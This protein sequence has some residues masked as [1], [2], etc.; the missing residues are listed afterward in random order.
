V[1]PRIAREEVAEL[2]EVEQSPALGDVEGCFELAV[3]K[4]SGGQVEDRARKS[5]DRQPA[6]RGDLI[7]CERARTVDADTGVAL[8]TGAPPAP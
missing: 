7:V 6:Q 4:P 8:A 1:A 5:R 3:G 2:V